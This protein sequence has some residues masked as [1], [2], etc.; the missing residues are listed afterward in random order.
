[1]GNY[2]AISV[3]KNSENILNTIEGYILQHFTR[4]SCSNNFIQSA[5]GHV[6]GSLRS[7]IL[8]RLVFACLLLMEPDENSIVVVE[9]ASY[10]LQY[11]VY[12]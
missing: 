12:L 8:G 4:L 5:E 9:T 7:R 6:D 10:T 3:R 1:M 11:P 2:A